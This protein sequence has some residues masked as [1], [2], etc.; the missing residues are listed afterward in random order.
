[1]YRSG[2][3][4]NLPGESVDKLIHPS[5]PQFSHMLNGDTIRKVFVEI[6][7]IAYEKLSTNLILKITVLMT[8]T[9]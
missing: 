9:E 5:V 8:M 6:I 2:L 7:E 3:D 1:M 4:P